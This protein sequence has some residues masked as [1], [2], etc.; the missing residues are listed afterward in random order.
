MRPVP[1]MKKLLIAV[2]ALYACSAMAGEHLEPERSQ[3]SG[4]PI[5]D[6]SKF[7]S[8]VNEAYDSNVL[9]R[10]I[11]FPAFDLDY[12]VGVKLEAGTYQIF[13]LRPKLKI[14]LYDVLEQAEKQAGTP[15]V[16]DG[17]KPTIIERRLASLRA[18]LPKDVKDVP[19][20]RC[21][22]EI[23]PKLA[24]RL[25]HLWEAMLLRTR[26]RKT[27]MLGFDGVTYHFSMPHYVQ[28]L[29]GKTWSPP[30]ESNAGML[31]KITETMVSMCTSGNRK[32]EAKLT[33]Q[34][35]ALSKRLKD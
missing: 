28:V 21:Q 27:T 3:F 12:A 19:I 25:V 10:A 20:D 32:L 11:V 6:R 1:K 9:A 15:R 24:K 30:S 2:A 14:E 22:I 8:T 18:L 5:L 35:D 31:V 29:A 33:E 34:V 7:L 23:E 16:D 13:H 4:R 17:G 26:Y